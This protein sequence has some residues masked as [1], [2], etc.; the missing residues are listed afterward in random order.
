MQTTI[1]NMS[2]QTHALVQERDKYFADLQKVMQDAVYMQAMLD[3][4][5][6]MCMYAYVY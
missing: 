5:V 4:S 6:C 3:V 1:H 2:I